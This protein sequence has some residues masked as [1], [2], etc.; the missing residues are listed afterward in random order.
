MRKALKIDQMKEDFNIKMQ[1]WTNLSFDNDGYGLI[2]KRKQ[3]L[4]KGNKNVIKGI[5]GNTT[6]SMYQES[7]K[8]FPEKHKLLIDGIES[9]KYISGVKG[10][11]PDPSIMNLIE[12]NQRIDNLIIDKITKMNS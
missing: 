1:K 3:D 10:K 11:C 6:T 2:Q 8:G 4:I 12:N 7:F 9:G 5:Y